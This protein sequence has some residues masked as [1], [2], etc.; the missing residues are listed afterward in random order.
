MECLGVL[1]KGHVRCGVVDASS[2]PA[3]GT[4]GGIQA[5]SLFRGDLPLNYK[6]AHMRSTND[7]NEYCPSTDAVSQRRQAIPRPPVQA[8]LGEFMAEALAVGHRPGAVG[9]PLTNSRRCWQPIE[10]RQAHVQ[11]RSVGGLIENGADEYPLDGI[12]GVD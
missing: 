1:P 10:V 8:C 7:A 2:L 9:V 6:F 11:A 4:A 12:G 5:G 3:L